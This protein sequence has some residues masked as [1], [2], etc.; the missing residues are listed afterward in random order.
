MWFLL[1]AGT[2]GAPFTPR[3]IFT[4]GDEAGSAVSQ[5]TLD[6]NDPPV[7]GRSVPMSTHTQRKLKE[8]AD[9]GPSPPEAA[10]LTN[11]HDSNPYLAGEVVGDRYRLDKE[12][13]RGGMGVV[14]VAHSLVLGIDVAVKLIRADIAGPGWASRMA[15]EAHAAA[16]IG[17]P[18]MVRVYDFGWTNRGDPF[19]VMELVHGDT[20]TQVIVRD[21]RIPAI[22]AI[23]TLLPIADGIRL[24]HERSII[25]R[26]IKPD[27]IL[28]A[29]D[30][31]GRLQPKLLD[32]GIAKV[33]QAQT[34]GKLTQVGA[35]LGSPQY[36]SPEQ[37]RGLESVDGRT[38]VWSLA[39]ALYESM[40]GKVPFD[41]PNY[42]ALMHSIIHD[43]PT[44]LS[45]HGVT[46]TQLWEIIQRALAKEP[47]DRYATMSEFGEALAL[48][49]FQH[50]IKEDLSGNSIR[51]QWLD[52]PLSTMQ[53][54]ARDGNAGPSSFA[55]KGR[56]TPG[57]GTGANE[58][59][60]LQLNNRNKIAVA[61]V[62]LG[63]SLA[64]A[65]MLQ[66]K[67]ALNPGEVQTAP[68]PPRSFEPLVAAPEPALAERQTA[69]ANAPQANGGPGAQPAG[70]AP[71]VNASAKKLQDP[72]SVARKPG[73]SARDF[74][75]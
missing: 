13:G 10:A 59:G 16:R 36:M 42:N 28:L 56:S 66:G 15:R 44:P 29:A 21:G 46:D 19:L 52:S 31:L 68:L 73:K 75:F 55:A 74:G 72:S 7:A 61:S 53:F 63:V 71:A 22:R 6:F 27:N 51:A 3:K 70:R 39:I 35:V 32:F 69:A 18:A 33:G 60:A 58:T 30:G 5:L 20:L 38:D 4:R 67:P 54:P 11:V 57:F 40:T 12:I 37:A 9:G 47:E 34:S 1:G 24:A 62:V 2:R 43:E 49:L 14:W 64:A 17:H 48:W 25:H 45:E 65:V 26:D 50:G 23:Q 8:L 41:Q